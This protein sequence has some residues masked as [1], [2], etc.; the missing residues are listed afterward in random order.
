MKNYLFKFKIAI[1]CIL[2]IISASNWAKSVTIYLDP[3][4]LP[5]LNQLMDFTQK[6]DDK[7]T[8]RIFG[9]TRFK[10]P[11]EIQKQYQH[12]DMVGIKDEKPTEE[13]FS[14]L[15]QYPE[16]LELDLHMSIAHATKL[17]QPILAYRFKHPSRV[18]IRSLN[19]YDDGSL[20]YVGLENLQDVDIP[21]AIAQAEQQLASFLMTGKAKFDNPI[22]A[23][24]VWQSQFPVKYHFLSP[25]YFEKAAFIKPLKEYLQDNYQKMA[26]FAYQDL[27]SEKQALYLKLVGFNDQI[28]QLLETTEKK[29]IFTGT[30]TWEAKTD[31]REYYAQQQLNLLKHFT[32]PNGELFIGDDYKVYFKGHP[33]GDEINEYILNNAKDI[34]NIPANISFEIL[35]MTGLLPDKVGGIASSLYFSL[36]KEKISH[37]IF[38][39]NKQVKSKEDALNNPYVKVMQRLGIIDESQVI[40]WDTL[41]QL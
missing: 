33:K 13:L 1:F 9:H 3:A 27:S 40:F 31:V 4:S 26:L 38:T 21:K 12:I 22:V 35:M 16:S 24:Y 18:S 41:K 39:T 15:D 30:T 34:I 28:K 25:E 10:M 32:Q 11:E 19:L 20:E 5:A 23:R 8:A 17:I 36:P 2:S 7:E 6:S 14:I 29:F 37:I